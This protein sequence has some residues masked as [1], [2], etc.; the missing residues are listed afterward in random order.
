MSF[1]SKGSYRTTR[2]NMMRAFDRLPAPVR[3]A[4]RNAAFN[5]APQPYATDIKRGDDP[6]RVAARVSIFDRYRMAKDRKKVWGPDYP[7][8]NGDG[9]GR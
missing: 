1:N 8:A 4:L 5:Y 9:G 7:A 3:E 6:V 2:E